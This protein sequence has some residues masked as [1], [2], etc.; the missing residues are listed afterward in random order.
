MM[1]KIGFLYTRTF[2]QFFLVAVSIYCVSS[3]PFAALSLTVNFVSMC[4]LG[5]VEP[6]PNCSSV[7]PSPV[8]HSVHWE[9]HRARGK[10]NWSAT[11]TK[12][13]LALSCPVGPVPSP[14]SIALS[15]RRHA[16]SSQRGP[17]TGA[18][19]WPGDTDC[20]LPTTFPAVSHSG[21]GPADA[22]LAKLKGLNLWNFG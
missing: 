3:L 20:S 10:Q 19:P 12:E 6:T 14:C 7:K 13:V 15:S 17:V 8:L 22:C 5:M 2:L 4:E 16:G 11:L 21:Y 9:I 1:R 18:F